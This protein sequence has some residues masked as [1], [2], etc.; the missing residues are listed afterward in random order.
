MF[1]FLLST[2][3]LFQLSVRISTEGNLHKSATAPLRQSLTVKQTNPFPRTFS[4]ETDWK[5]HFSAK[6]FKFKKE[7]QLKL[8]E[9]KKILENLMAVLPKKHLDA[10][11]NLEVRN[12][13]DDSRGMA[14]KETLILHL[15]AITNQ[16]EF[17]AVFLHEMGH[18]VDLGMITSINGGP[19]EFY[20]NNKPIFEKDQSVQFYRLSWQTSYTIKPTA[21]KKDFVSGYTLTNAFEDFAES[22]LFYRAHGEKFREKMANSEVLQQKY[23]FL[24]IVV[25]AGQEFQKNKVCENFVPDFLWDATQLPIGNSIMY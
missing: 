14:N 7:D 15:P 4:L 23:E 3:M 18:I 22:Y 5:G 24:K 20:D 17:N 16:D 25:F 12:V 1:T 19:T 21:N 2:L 6:N 11:K 13:F 10:L 8:N 9:T